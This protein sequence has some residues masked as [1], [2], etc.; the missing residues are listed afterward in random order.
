MRTTI[1]AS[2]AEKRERS[3][4]ARMMAN[5]RSVDRVAVADIVVA[6]HREPP[7]ARTSCA[8]CSGNAS[9]VTEHDSAPSTNTSQRPSRPNTA[10]GAGA[11]CAQPLA[12]PETWM[13]SP[14]GQLPRGVRDRRRHR[15]RGDLARRADRRAG[16]GDDPA[17]RIGGIDD[18]AERFAR[19]RASGRAR[20]RQARRTAAR[21]P[22][23][24]A[25]RTRRPGGRHRSGAISVSESECPNGRPTPNASPADA[26]NAD[27]D[28]IG[29]DATRA[30]ADRR[31]D[32]RRRT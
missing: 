8:I 10:T 2:S 28:R 22:A 13:T 21:G 30:A 9:A 29:G 18:E 25:R 31:R 12:Q 32:R 14:V 7:R 24:C 20:R 26:M 17:A 4:S 15:A 27:A 19:R 5:E 1:S 6:A 3:V 11:G 23:R 16:A